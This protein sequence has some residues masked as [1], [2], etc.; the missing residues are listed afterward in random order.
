MAPRT[1]YFHFISIWNTSLAPSTS[2]LPFSAV[3]SS[4]VPHNSFP[5]WRRSLRG[6][7]CGLV[8][9]FNYTDAS[10]QGVKGRWGSFKDQRFRPEEDFGV[11]ADAFSQDA[12]VNSASGHRGNFQAL[13]C[14]CQKLRCW[15]SGISW[16]SGLRDISD[17]NVNFAVLFHFESKVDYM[18]TT[19]INVF[20]K[21]YIFLQIQFLYNYTANANMILRGQIC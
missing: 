2:W 15:K 20:Y 14:V 17:K 3:V 6:L 19:L 18:Q 1:G 16:S 13:G 5:L 12:P 8:M 4:S 10:T 11:L 21:R 7:H 9:I